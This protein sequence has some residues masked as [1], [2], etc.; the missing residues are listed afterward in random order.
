MAAL[1]L[2]LAATALVLPL[3]LAA[4]TPAHACTF[5]LR[6]SI[7]T[8]E[9]IAT[10]T[11]GEM[12][13]LPP[14]SVEHPEVLGGR[15]PTEIKFAVEEYLKGAGPETLLIFQPAVDITNEGGRITAIVDSR[16]CGSLISLGDPYVVLGNR[17]DPLRYE[18]IAGSGALSDRQFVLDTIHE[19]LSEPAILPPLGTG[20]PPRDESSMT[21]LI[22]AA[23][24]GF[25]FASGVLLLGRRH[26]S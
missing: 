25:A 6:D 5:S 11:I 18:M 1:R 20:P 10:G 14:E 21:P 19:V 17:S 16:V 13:V 12:L 15:T 9:I 3:W 26:D 24:A 8:A 7:L 22:A 2:L 4:T 23:I